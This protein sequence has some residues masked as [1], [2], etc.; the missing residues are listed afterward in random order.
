MQTDFSARACRVEHLPRYLSQAKPLSQATVCARVF[1]KEKTRAGLAPE[2]PGRRQLFK[3]T[4]SS[5]RTR[6]SS[7]SVSSTPSPASAAAFPPPPHLYSRPC[8]PFRGGPEQ[9]P[10]HPGT[11]RGTGG[12]GAAAAQLLPRVRQEAALWA[13]LVQ[14][15]HVACHFLGRFDRPGWGVC[16]VCGVCMVCAWY[17]GELVVGWRATSLV[18]HYDYDSPPPSTGCEDFAFRLQQDLYNSGRTTARER[19]SG[20]AV[21]APG[22]GE[23]TDKAHN[24]VAP[25]RPRPWTGLAASVA[26]DRDGQTMSVLPAQVTSSRGRGRGTCGYDRAARGFPDIAVSWHIRERLRRVRSL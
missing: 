5:A 22:A 7:S 14:K 26:Q 2:P 8:G 19:A 18:A 21:E 13:E 3:Q 20:H 12:R 1:E 25:E 10:L 15:L 6:S 24:L 16:V 11:G 17:V 4:S 9:T 23:R